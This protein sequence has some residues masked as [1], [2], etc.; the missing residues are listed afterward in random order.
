MT[1]KEY[2]ALTPEK[3]SEIAGKLRSGPWK[4]ETNCEGVCLKCRGY[5]T[6]TDMTKPCSVPDPIPIDWNHAK[7]L[8]G[9]FEA[10]YNCY[11]FIQALQSVHK[12]VK[13][14]HT[15]SYWVIHTDTGMQPAHIFAALLKMK[16]ILE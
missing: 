4:H 1:I 6:D 7:A 15:F 13:S 2:L 16:R 9:E 10:K 3:Q 12:V 11:K 8:Q 14:M 5:Y